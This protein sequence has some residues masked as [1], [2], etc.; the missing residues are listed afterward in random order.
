LALKQHLDD[1]VRFDQQVDNSLSYVMPFIEQTK[2]VG[3]GVRVL[4]VGT[5][6]GGVLLPFIERGC[7]CV[8][9]DLAP[10]RI[11]LAKGFL[12]KEVAAGKVEFL[13]QNIYE[14]AFQDKFRNSFDIIILKDV[15]EHV[16]EQE[17]FVPFLKTFLKQGGQIFFGFPPWYMP[18]GGHQQVCRKKWASVLPYYHILPRFIYKGMLQ[19]AGEEKGVIDE[20]MEIK[21][22]QITIERF[23]RIVKASGLKVL[24]KEHYLINPIY[25]YKFGLTPRRQWTPFSWIPYFRDFVT[26][27]VYYTIG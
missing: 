12:A 7:Y 9:V 6:E 20:L 3:A 19:M 18:F 2:P 1:K 5:A 8:G 16:P 27:C 13:C 25:K 10:V 15:I 24:H 17:K 11:D 23:E 4:E 14:D 22:T 21:D 26:T